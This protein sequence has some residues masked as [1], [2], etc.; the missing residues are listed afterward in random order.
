MPAGRRKEKVRSWLF[1]VVAPFIPVLAFDRLAAEWHA[2]ERARLA[3][4]GR[5]P[6]FA[7]G[8]IAGIAHIHCLTVVREMRTIFGSSKTS[9]S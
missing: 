3:A 9:A 2:E 5:T 7:D 4:K 1:G 8:Q 6:P